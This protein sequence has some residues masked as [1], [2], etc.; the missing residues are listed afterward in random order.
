VLTK[1]IPMV[2]GFSVMLNAGQNYSDTRTMAF[3]FIKVHFDEIMKGNPNIFGNDLGSFLPQAG[4]SFCDA[5]SRYDLQAF[6]GPRVGKYVG[7]PRT[8]AQV[9]EGIDLCIA[10]K[11]AQEASVR[12]FLE[13]Y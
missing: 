8:L 11:A 12:A 6:F 9:V 13:K 5:R 3:D 7:A 10:R 1:S 2:D 4:A